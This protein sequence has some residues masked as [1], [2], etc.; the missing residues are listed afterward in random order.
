M[1]TNSFNDISRKLLVSLSLAFV[2]ALT[3]VPETKA[4]ESFSIYIGPG[5]GGF[6]FR[7]D[8][9]ARGDYFPPIPP[10]PG[11]PYFCD[12]RYDYCGGDDWRYRQPYH[13]DWRRRHDDWH[14]NDWHRR[15]DDWHHRHGRHH[16][17]W[18]CRNW[19]D[20]CRNW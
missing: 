7:D 4:D 1:K 3:I 2:L 12:P 8:Y 6:S 16:D 9:Y 13:D 18:R 20:Y 19:P 15:H 10:L 17:Q 14:H 5:G 11:R